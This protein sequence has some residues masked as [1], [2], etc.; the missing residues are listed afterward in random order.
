MYSVSILRY[1]ASITP[2]RYCTKIMSSLH[3]RRP[4][5]LQQGDLRRKS[6]LS[7]GT[8]II[9]DGGGSLRRPPNTGESP[10]LVNG[11]GNKRGKSTMKNICRI[12]KMIACIGVVL[13]LAV[14]F[15][16]L[17]NLILNNTN[18]S[19]GPGLRANNNIANNNHSVE[20]INNSNI[21]AEPG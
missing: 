16:R 17:R 4:P 11:S 15:F 1:A 19:S 7:R 5:K 9:K 3:A 12:F 2:V 18:R 8:S 20:S 6:K 21:P 14:P 10:R 13:A